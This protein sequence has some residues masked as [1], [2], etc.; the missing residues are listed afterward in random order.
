MKK[1]AGLFLLIAALLALGA[2]ATVPV[3]SGPVF[4]VPADVPI[5]GGATAGVDVTGQHTV[6]SYDADVTDVD[7]V[8]DY[9][10]SSL[11]EV[12]WQETNEVDVITDSGATMVRV[13]EDGDELTVRVTP[14]E[15]GGPA[16]VFIE[17][18]RAE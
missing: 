2:C 15:A 6:V 12:G 13:N 4:T 18:D 11:V 5:I 3:A 14:D 17:V 8:V 9:Y 10:R 16:H 1:V 7:V